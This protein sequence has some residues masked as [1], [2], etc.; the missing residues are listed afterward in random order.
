MSLRT[1]LLTAA[2]LGAISII[3]TDV[4]FARRGTDEPSCDVFREDRQA[5]CRRPSRGLTLVDDSPFRIRAEGGE[6]IG[7]I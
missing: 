4:A 7:F 3:A 2:A 6:A 5:D 1:K